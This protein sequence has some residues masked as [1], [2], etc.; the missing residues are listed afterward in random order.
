MLVIASPVVTHRDMNKPLLPSRCARSVV[1][2]LLVVLTS[3]DRARAVDA[4]LV[5]DTYVDNLSHGG[6]P[7]SNINYGSS[8]ELRVVRAATRVA[9]TFLKF[10]LGTLPPETLPSDVTHARL[11]LWVNSDSAAVGAISMSPVTSPWDEETLKD[12]NSGGLTFGQPKIL[13]LAVSSSA[14]FISID[15]TDWVKAWLDGSLPNEG[16]VIEPGSPSATLTLAFDSKESELTGHEPRLD[17]TL[18]RVGL[19]GPAGPQGE[20]GDQGVVGPAGATGAQGPVGPQGLQGARGVQGPAG[21]QGIAGP[22]GA[23]GPAGPIGPQGPEG[24]AGVWP[25][26]IEPRGDLSMGEFTQGPTP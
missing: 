17:I 1:T 25:A 21:E 22:A 14:S 7:A 12:S 9:R 10:D 5:Q 18:G 11:L 23:A 6:K 15:V 13:N 3:V 26:R 19:Q 4:L 20:K 8:G 24:P 16:F 2:I